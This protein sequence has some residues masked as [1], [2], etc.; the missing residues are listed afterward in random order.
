M[1]D[2]LQKKTFVFAEFTWK[3]YYKNKI[4]WIKVVYRYNCFMNNSV[5]VA[6]KQ[7]HS[8]FC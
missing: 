1:T 4:C 6:K 5:Y 3:I 8:H 2:K 7:H